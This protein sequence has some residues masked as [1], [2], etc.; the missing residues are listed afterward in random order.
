MTPEKLRDRRRW[1]DQKE[2][3]KAQEIAYWA[4]VEREA[5][6]QLEQR[7]QE[8]SFQAA[9]AAVGLFPS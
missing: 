2:V 5:A 6:R 7:K 4:S 9:L 3:I 8:L 1:R